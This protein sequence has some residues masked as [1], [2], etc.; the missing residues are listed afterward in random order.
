MPYLE[1][2]DTLE[3][4][5][6]AISAKAE[7]QQP[8]GY[9]GA[10]SI[11]NDCSRQIWYMGNGVKGLPWPVS[12]LLK[13]EDGHR[14]EQLIIDRLRLLPY[15]KVEGQ[16]AGFDLGYLKGHVDGIITG[17]CEAPHTPHILE[18]KA[19]DEVGFNK[20][21]KAVEKHGEKNALKMWEPRYYYQAIIYM[22]CMSFT[23]HY[24]VCA[25][26]GGRDMQAIRTEA[27]PDV[28]LGMIE[29]AKRIANMK[30]PPER[31]SERPD[32]WQC[33]MCQYREICHK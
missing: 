14:T 10:S 17:L 31:F 16:Q 20:L 19:V 25:T 29:R 15:I 8:R 9:I 33:R 7:E 30:E 18:V 11:G 13:F 24:L 27:A 5:R 28:A 4:V 26:A 12:T 32:N 2:I 3:E 1:R 23:R 21:K 6:R 22:H